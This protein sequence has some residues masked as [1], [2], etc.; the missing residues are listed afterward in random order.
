MHLKFL[1]RIIFGCFVLL[2]LSLLRLQ[3]IQGPYFLQLSQN[4]RIKFV[5]LAAGRGI[6]YD[7]FGKV[8]A[9]TRSCFNLAIIPQQTKDVQKLIEQISPHLGLSQDELLANFKRNLLAPF[10]P[11][12]IAQDLPKEKAILLECKEAE[13]PGLLIQVV[14]L[15]DYPYAQSLGHILGYLGRTREK[16][17]TQS[18][19]YGLRRQDLVGRSGMEE[20]FD[21]Y[22]RGE[23]GGMQVEVNSRGYQVK[24][25]GSKQPQSGGEL[26]LTIWAELQ[27]L[28]DDLLAEEIGACIVLNPQNGEV[29]S[30]VS[31]PSFD[32]N[33][34][35]AALNGKQPESR[36]VQR[37]LNS[38]EAVLLNRAI[39]GMYPP[40]SI[41]K[42]V[43][44]C[45]ALENEKITTKTSFFCPGSLRLGGRDFL[46]WK[47]DGHG[48][49]DIFSGIRHSCNVFFYN[50]GLALGA[51]KLTLYAHKFGFGSFT[52]IELPYQAQ[53]LVPSKAWKLKTYREKWYD[54]ETANFSIG[55]GYLLATPLQV[56]RMVSAVANGGN[57][58]QPHLVKKIA[59]QELV[60]SRKDLGLKK[61]TIKAIKTGM[62]QVIQTSDGTGH[63]AS[64][65]SIEWAGK[66]ATAQAASGV[67]HGWFVG[68]YPVEQPEVLVLVFLEH[69]GSGGEA[70]ARIAK[71]IMQYVIEQHRGER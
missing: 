13:I 19:D 40:G 38:Q 52:G 20:T 24:L 39:S 50:S 63:K 16:E 43:T 45:A 2:A 59:Q 28:V 56:A 67:A 42:I 33:L 61:E 35:I 66:T 21:D 44:A 54:G 3:I 15:R 47:L 41:F 36:R 1:R 48:N 30:L 29:L 58:I 60:V 23:P 65:A 34:F 46:C 11:V 26:V 64:I 51:D 55:Q 62:R 7:R 69:G 31:K 70:P 14:P 10:I 6:I 9:N 27:E 12:V 8:L 25:L 18:K 4:N 5:N 53:G 71:S 68:F 37:L 49:E 57:L 22:L 17:L 32:P